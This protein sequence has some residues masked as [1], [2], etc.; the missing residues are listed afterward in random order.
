MDRM[1]RRAL[2]DAVALDVQRI[3]DPVSTFEPSARHTRQMRQML[4]DPLHWA[5]SRNRGAL[6]ITAQWAAV[7]LLFVSLGFGSVMLF[8][9]PAR[10]AVER[11]VVEWYETH[12][13]YRYSGERK[14]IL[15][16]Y[17][18]TGLPE[19]VTELERIEMYELTDV[20]Y[21]NENGEL[22]SFIYGSTAQG[23]ATVFVPNGDTVTE[24][25][26]GR[27]RGMLFIPQDPESMTKLTWIDDEAGVQFTIAA[28]LDEPDMIRLA[29]SLRREKE[30]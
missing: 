9:A 5:R 30:K 22:I 14:G 3:S 24:V 26:V 1:M 16:R 10:A 4:K 25:M 11:W 23:G 29:E 6:R 18:L 19:G 2:L 21:G 17:E 13:V 12:I 20:L 15:P 7:V 27:L 28:A 8:S